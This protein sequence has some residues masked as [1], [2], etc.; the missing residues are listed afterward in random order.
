MEI[1]LFLDLLPED[2]YKNSGIPIKV[3]STNL[4][5]D[6]LKNSIAIVGINEDRNSNHIGIKAGADKI[7]EALKQLYLKTEETVIDFGNIKVGT[8]LKDS[9]KAIEIISTFFFEKAILPI[10]IGGAADC[11]YPIISSFQEKEE[12]T[13]SVVNSELLVGNKQEFSARNYLNFIKNKFQLNKISHLASQKY[14]CPEE[15]FD[16][17]YEHSFP[18][19]RLG[20][21]RNNIF[22]VEPYIREANI[23]CLHGSAIR[24]CDFPANA[25]AQPNGL[26][27][28]E[29]CQVARYCG[30]S[31][32]VKSFIITDYNT[33]LDTNNRTSKLIA[34]IVWH[35]IEG[36]AYREN[37]YLT[38]ENKNLFVKYVVESLQNE[39][40][41]NFYQHPKT[42]RWWLEIPCNNRD[43]VYYVACSQN[44]YLTACDK[45][46]PDIWNLER[47]RINKI[48]PK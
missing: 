41:F 5:I 21:L 22:E 19:N 17:F 2:F 3:F 48:T 7:R 10:Y 40:F 9:Y 47:E 35:F 24:A 31:Q 38:S 30:I 23:V 6:S 29:A 34:Q 37:D 46:I 16:F 15:D 12:I 43:K 45:G 32:H 28:E 20:N 26:T 33:L 18:I 14:L 1:Q 39:S 4:T 11:L 36:I 42:K 13:L 27:G 44:D 8:S 25:Y